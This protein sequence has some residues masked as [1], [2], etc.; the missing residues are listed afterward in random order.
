MSIVTMLKKR[1]ALL[2]PV[3]DIFMNLLNYFFHIVNSWFL[4]KGDYGKLNA[5]LGLSA[6]LIV[7]GISLQ[8][9]TAKTIALSS[10]KDSIVIG[11]ALKFALFS[12]I[13]ITLFFIIASGKI[14]ELTSTE[15]SSYILLAAIFIFNTFLCVLRGI[16]QGKKQFLRLNASLYIEVSVKIAVLFILIVNFK[17]IDS[18]MAAILAGM[19]VSTLHG[20][21]LLFTRLKEAE[22]IKEMIT[23]KE[24]LSVTAIYGSNF[25]IYFFTSVDLIMANYILKIDSGEYSVIIRYSQLI[26]FAFSSLL[27]VFLPGMAS[28]IKENNSLKRRLLRYTIV[29]SGFYFLVILAYWVVLPVTVEYMFGSQY[30]GSSNYLLLGALVYIP[31]SMIFFLININIVLDTKKYIITLFIVAILVV[32]VLLN[33]ER[34]I[35]SFLKNEAVL[36]WSAALVLGVHTLLEVKRYEYRK[37]NS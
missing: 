27:T 1:E 10:E 23:L 34:T 5:L 22:P 26:T 16:F 4:S 24:A 35:S 21:I 11:K 20:V 6:I 37:N 8:I 18:A 19:A 14:M 15:L 12:N 29:I 25:F 3:F 17:S 13:V 31:L 33:S 9:Y 7:A 32:F 36:Y 2:F 28:A 30:N